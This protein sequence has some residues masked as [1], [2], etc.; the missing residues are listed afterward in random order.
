MGDRCLM[1]SI[2]FMRDALVSREFT[3]ALAEGDVGRVY[4][5]LKVSITK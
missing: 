5:A 4:E 1:Q 3:Y 2:A